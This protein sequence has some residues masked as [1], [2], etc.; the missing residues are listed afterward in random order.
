MSAYLT[1]R[2][3]PHTELK[4]WRPWAYEP[5]GCSP[6]VGQSNLF[7]QSVNFYSSSQQLKLNKC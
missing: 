7:G 1:R 6:R 2:F 5:G 3:T 4:Y